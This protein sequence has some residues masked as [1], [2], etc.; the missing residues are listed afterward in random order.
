[1]KALKT[2]FLFFYFLV[3]VLFLNHHRANAQQ[4]T[5]SIVKY[6][7]DLAQ[8]PKNVGDLTKA[9]QFFDSKKEYAV[10]KKD[11]VMV[12]YCLYTI[13]SI[14]Y[15]EGFYYDSENS[16]VNAL[17]LL[18]NIKKTDYNIGLKKSLYNHLAIIYREQ[19]N[20]N[21]AIDLYN[22]AL[23]ISQTI[24]DSL[25]I[26]NNKSNVYKDKNDFVSAEKELQKAF[27]LIHRTNDTLTI[28][29][30]LDNLGFI[31][32]KLNS[33]N[34]L[35]LMIEAL[36][37]RKILK[38]LK[39]IHTSQMHLA[40]YYL[41]RNNTLKAKEYA[42]SAYNI[43]I[44]INSASYKKNSLSLLLKLEGNKY[45]KE[46]L[47][48]SDSIS[49]ARQKSL[50]KFALMKYDYSE[51]ERI[52]QENEFKFKE[53]ESEK[54]TQKI[55]YLTIGVF[56]LLASIFLYFLLKSKHKKEKLQ[57]VI[58][59]ESRISKK[60]HDEVANDV[61]HV[62]TKLQSSTPKNSAILDDLENIYTKTRDISKENSAIDV[63]ENF[64]ELLTDLLLSYKN[65]EVNII[66]R[67]ISKIK[68]N[69]VSDITKT[70]IYRVLQ[71]LMTNMRKHSN[72]SLVVL[73][74]NQTNTKIT[75]DYNDDG[76]GGSIQK[77]TGLQNVENR[78][79]TIKGTI[80]FESEKEKG[81]KAKITI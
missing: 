36:N 52:A 72:A 60:I 16:A 37:Y 63:H 53:S 19:N 33:K 22:N 70:T 56:I 6:Y 47:K 71:E 67:N 40:E 21:K 69:T 8:N 44:R 65:H 27:R 66:T 59:T 46:Y 41:D 15:K 23:I 39:T 77:N 80:T 32:S 11:T 48:I 42:N 25:V 76:V 14:E 4:A 51:K 24:K 10:L 73:S 29:L 7:S 79:K 26:F 30:I 3:T 58:I 43:A 1:M 17:E 31:K 2:S 57:E 64:N 50:N 74:F 38:S 9:Y 61:Y 49:K 34:A 35:P 5:D 13:A 75:I 20:V 62:M 78:I 68:W 81:F 18:N 45:S 54:K 12:I 55:I 28:A